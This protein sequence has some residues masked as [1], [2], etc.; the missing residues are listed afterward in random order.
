M[1][2]MLARLFSLERLDL[3]EDIVQETFIK[4]LRT[5]SFGNRPR[6]PE[7][8]A[9]LALMYFHAARLP[10]RISIDGDPVLRREQD[11]SFW[12]SACIAEGLACLKRSQGKQ[13]SRYHLEA[14]IASIHCTAKQFT[15]TNWDTII[16]HYDLLDEQRIPFAHFNCVIAI[17]FRDGSVTGITERHTINTAHTFDTSTRYLSALAS[18]HF[19]TQHYATAEKYDQNALQHS[20]VDSE[21]QF[22][23]KRITLCKSHLKGA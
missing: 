15:E 9:L 3:A 5:C 17:G 16:R 6:N 21:W 13:I 2:A 1:L 19:D 4:A 22:L 12:D 20:G 11:R 7:A 18:F 14:G 23:T 10:S 8:F